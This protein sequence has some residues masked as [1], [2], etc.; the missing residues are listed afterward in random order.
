MA[1]PVVH[2]EITASNANTSKE[3]YSKLFDWSFQTHEGFDYHLVGPASDKS[4]GGG[5]GPVQGDQTPMLTVYIQVDDLQKYLDRA[6][7]L[8]GKTTLPPTPIPGVGSCAMFTDPDGLIIGL[9][10]PGE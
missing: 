5:L 3:F 8:G 9:F 1:A 2:F 10:K 7:N 6:E 4:I